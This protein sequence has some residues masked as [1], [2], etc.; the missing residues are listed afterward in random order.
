[1]ETLSLADVGLPDSGGTAVIS[2]TKILYTPAYDFFGTETFTYTISDG[3]LTDTAVVVVNVNNV[4]DAPELTNLDITPEPLLEGQE[5]TFTA[6]VNDPG[7]LDIDFEIRWDFDDGA[8]VSGTLTPTHTYL[9]DGLYNLTITLTDTLGASNEY[10]IPLDVGNVAPDVAVTSGGGSAE[11][12]QP[13]S[14]SGGFFDPGADSHTIVWDFGDGIT[15]TGSLTVD[16]AFES[17]GT[18]NVT[19]TVTDD[20]G[21]VG[22]DSVEVVVQSAVIYMPIVIKVGGNGSNA[23]SAMQSEMTPY[24][25]AH[26]PWHEMLLWDGRRWWGSGM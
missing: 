21:G 25:V 10:V 15:T 26:T 4:N 19:L 13:L 11:I 1:V 3:E 9:D 8:I 6:T 7:L 24:L 12:D 2:G 22:S 5:Q 23:S 20:E 16:H 18:F 17:A 14:F